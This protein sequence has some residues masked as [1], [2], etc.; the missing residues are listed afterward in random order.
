MGKK[1]QVFGLLGLCLAVLSLEQA[2]G[3]P[4]LVFFI[5]MELS[6]R[7]R[8]WERISLWLLVGLGLAGM[9]NLP[10]SWGVGL[11]FG[12]TG[13]F[14]LSQSALKGIHTRAILVSLMGSLLVAN[15][16]HIPWNTTTLT[17]LLLSIAG[18][19]LLA[20]QFLWSREMKII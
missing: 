17:T 20:R 18:A 7:Y 12:A 5:L 4:F 13:L 2:Y 10:L 11:V 14:L 15:L 6:F 1:S 8:F 3:V 16:A 9:L 19:V